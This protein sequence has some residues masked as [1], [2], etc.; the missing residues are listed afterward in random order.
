MCWSG[1]DPRSFQAEAAG[2]VDGCYSP[3]D[4]EIARDCLSLV[5]DRFGALGFVA[6]V[7]VV[8]FEVSC[9]GLDLWLFYS[10]LG[11]FVVA[12][13]V[14]VGDLPGLFGYYSSLSEFFD[15]FD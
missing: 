6:V 4:D 8:D 2:D 10:D 11:F 9:R 15:Y 5:D 1:I 14:V 3:C 7:V 12:V 13:A